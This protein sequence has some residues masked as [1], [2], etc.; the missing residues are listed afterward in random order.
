LYLLHLDHNN[1]IK[2]TFKW[3][4]MGWVMNCDGI[5]ARRQII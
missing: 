4:T 3:Q 5:I 1:D 2:G